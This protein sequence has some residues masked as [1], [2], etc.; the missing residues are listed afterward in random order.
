MIYVTAGDP[1]GVGPEIVLRSFRD[2]ALAGKFVLVGDAEVIRECA[3]HLG[4]DVPVRSVLQAEDWAPGVL[5]VLD[6][7]AMAV[8]KLSVGRVSA[9]GGAAALRYLERATEIVSAGQDDAL[10]T[11]PVNKEAVR[12]TA[13]AFTGHT[14][15]LA[16]AA[17]TKRYTMMLASDRLAATHVSTHVSLADAIRSVRRDRIVDVICLTHQALSRFVSEPRIA[18]AGLNPH[19]GEAGAFGTED[20]TEIAP[21]VEQTRRSGLPVDGPVAPDTVFVRAVNGAYDAVVCMYHDQGH[22]PM[23]LLDFHGSVNVTLGLPFVRTSVDHGTAFDIA[24]KGTASTQSFVAAFRYAA[25]LVGKY[26]EAE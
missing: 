1:N 22:I 24:W 13:S 3:E 10:V 6:V 23:K 19:G 21:A 2:R 8:S 9:E 12:L 20:M 15:F 11:L 26:P 18:V 7:G 5:N 25:K 16:A 4:I 14:E 17:G